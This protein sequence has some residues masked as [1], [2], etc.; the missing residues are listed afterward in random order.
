MITF[1]SYLKYKK[2]N[3]F[4]FSCLWFK[5]RL[6]PVWKVHMETSSQQSEVKRRLKN[7]GR[8]KIRKMKFKLFIFW[9]KNKKK[10]MVSNWNTCRAAHCVAI[11]HFTFFLQKIQDISLLFFKKNFR[12]KNSKT[13]ILFKSIYYNMHKLFL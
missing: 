11:K 2:K 4:S 8:K 9:R 7:G 5:L 6:W 10:Q 1:L 12:L 13:V 3:F